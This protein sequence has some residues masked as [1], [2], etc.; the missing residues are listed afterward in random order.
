MQKAQAPGICPNCEGRR[1]QVGEQ[2]PEP[3]CQR[4]GY[5]FIPEN[6]YQ[7]AK[8]F[9]RQEGK[10]LDPLLGR[11]L[12]RDP[13]SYLLIGKLGEGGM[14]AVYVA[15][16]RLLDAEGAL[17]V[18]REVAVKLIL[19]PEVRDPKEASVP[20]SE[21][22]QQAISDSIKRFAREVQAISALNHP[23]IV[24]LYDCGV[25]KLSGDKNKLPY[26]AL[27]YVKH[28]RT[29]RRAF[30][31]MRERPGIV[32]RIF[33]QILD[34]LGEAHKSGIIHRDMK[35]ENV[36]VAPVE[37]NPYFVKVLDFGLA[38]AVGELA[39]V[40]PA[41]KTITQTGQFCG[42]PL[43]MAPEQ[44]SRQGEAPSVDGRADLYAVAIMLFEVFTGVPPFDAPTPV[45]VIWRKLNQEHDP[46]LLEQAQG[47]PRGLREFLR[48]GMARDPKARF[49]NASEMLRALEDA[50]RGRT[51]SALDFVAPTYSS[52]QERPK[53]PA[54][55]PSEDASASA[56]EAPAGEAEEESVVE[57]TLVES[58]EALA[59]KSWFRSKWLFGIVVPLVIVF[60]GGV[61]W[62]LGGRGARTEVVSKVEPATTAPTN[63]APQAPEPKPAPAQGKETVEEKA[64]S[65]SP[66]PSARMKVRFESEPEGGE[67]YCEGRLLGKT[68]FDEVFIGE[69]SEREFEFKMKG[70][71]TQRIKSLVKDGA[72]VRITMEEDYPEP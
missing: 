29:L 26:M 36:M 27:E 9:S 30:A 71:R 55:R 21:A 64:P 65:P 58:S 35:P 51:T 15:L 8:E 41:L 66:P 59:S 61:F 22:K 67:V 13:Y 70:Y 14:G 40:Y 31:D 16:Q 68:P 11:S 24:K 72:V 69:S 53:T 17:A 42:T 52:S 23:N 50:L 28:G 63:I 48:K 20:V 57:T 39:E 62:F 4:K 7:S 10:Q 60:A 45:E 1:G 12:D 47:L 56:E 38:K 25:A 54:S 5:C 19:G 6:W 33:E 32:L 37:G 34:A 49:A 46:L 44:V 43:Y 2:C 3:I 18:H